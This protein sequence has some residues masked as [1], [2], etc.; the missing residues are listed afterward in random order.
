MLSQE[1]IGRLESATP[2][3]LA[4]RRMDAISFIVYKNDMYLS[5]DVM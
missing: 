5:E 1:V 4:A 2:V 3:S